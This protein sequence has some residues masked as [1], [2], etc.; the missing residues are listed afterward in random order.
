MVDPFKADG[1]SIAELSA[2][3]NVLPNNYGL[4]NAM[5]LF[6]DRGV[7]TRTILVE[8]QN[9]VL[10]LLPTVAPGG[11]AT[12]GKM[13]KRKVRSFV[14]PHIPHIDT[15]LPSEVNGIRSFGMENAVD[16]VTLKVREKLATMK[17]KHD[18][19]REWLR[20]G[21]LKGIIYDADA[22]TVLYNLYTEFGIS[23]ASAV[24][25]VGK[26]LTLSFGLDDEDTDVLAKCED[27]HEHIEVNLQGEI[28]TG[29]TALVSRGFFDALRS[30]PKVEKA[31]AAYAA[32]GQNLASDYR[33]KFVFGDVTFQ[34]YSGS[35][36]NTGGTV[37]KFITANQGIAFPAGT[38]ETF[39]TFNAPAEFNETVNTPGLPYYAKQKERDF[40]KGWDLYTES[41]PLPI[42]LRPSVLVTLTV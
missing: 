30:H 29:I 1:Y 23:A 7:T 5:N 6:P 2:A 16:G 31:F 42:C 26:Y 40:G 21:A 11:A 22:A 37:S 10:T 9:G 25:D 17:A 36:T 34:V 35:A 15:V 20:M 4:L 18:I 39:R 38:N 8:E 32:L 24:G 3:I 14:I 27:L 19:T 28:M 12:T 33:N 13:G 41:N